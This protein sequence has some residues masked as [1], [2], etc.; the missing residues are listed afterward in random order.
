MFIVLTA[1]S[2]KDVVPRVRI[3]TYYTNVLKDVNVLSKLKML[4]WATLIATLYPE[5]H[6]T[7]R[8]QVAS[9][10]PVGYYLPLKGK[11]SALTS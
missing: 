7:D 1:D 5:P 11:H 9:T 8:L 2:S 6:V 4:Y 3:H 10:I